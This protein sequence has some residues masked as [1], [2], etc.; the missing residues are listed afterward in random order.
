MIQQFWNKAVEGDERELKLRDY[1]YASELGGGLID[2]YL[3]M[4]ATPVTN[5]PNGRAL[6]KMMA[7]NF[8][9]AV[10]LYVFQR[11]GIL[12][13]SQKRFESDWTP[14][15]VH[16]KADIIIGGKVDIDQARKAAQQFEYFPEMHA[17]S[18]KVVEGLYL[19]GEIPDTGY[20]VK[21]IAT[22]KADDFEKKGDKAEPVNTHRLQAGFYSIESMLPYFILSYVCRDDLRMTEFYVYNTKEIQKEIYNDVYQIK[23]YLDAN[24][25]PPLEPMIVI[26]GGKFSKNFNVEYSS[27]LTML[28]GFEQPRD[29][30]ELVKK[31]IAKWNRVL[32]RYKNGDKITDK[33]KEVR[34]EIETRGFDF[35]KILSSFDGVE[36]EED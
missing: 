10:I 5:P 9:E 27:Y 19:H 17:I 29:Y 26:E 4:K 8:T 33:N 36:E 11:A 18:L 25:R 30:S 35:E 16:G 1:V 14:L 23:G 20:E 24:E 28:Y 7:G 31:D 22:Y 13:H 2:R 15:S 32:A 34:E 12:R 21:S 6:R 3:K